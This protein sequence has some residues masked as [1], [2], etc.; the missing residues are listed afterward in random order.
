MTTRN[1][2]EQLFRHHY[3]A[4]LLFATRLVH[5]QEAARDIVHDVFASLL[6]NENSTV[7]SGYLINGVRFA[8]LKHI[9]NL[10]VRNR[11]NCLYALDC[12]EIENEEWPDEKNIQLIRE[13]I[14]TKLS[15]QCRRVLRLRFTCGMKYHEIAEE[16]SISETAVYKHLRHAFIVLRQNFSTNERQN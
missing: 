6:N 3:K 14:D 5:D 11:L 15:E 10:S 1:D 12:M 4:M 8:C 13:I 7:T 9:R 16:L 2:I